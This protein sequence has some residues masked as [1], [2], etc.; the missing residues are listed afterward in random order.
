MY[1]RGV[2]GSQASL[3]SYTPYLSGESKQKTF[4][5]SFELGTFLFDDYSHWVKNAR[6]CEPLFADG[7]F[8]GEARGLLIQAPGKPV[9][10]LKVLDRIAFGRVM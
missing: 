7:D 10:I 1:S 5:Q 6:R 9:R 3:S 8:L 4:G 2:C